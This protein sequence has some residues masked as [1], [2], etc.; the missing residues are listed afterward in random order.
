MIRDPFELLNGST[1]TKDK[2]IR[3]VDSKDQ[4]E[5]THFFL[6]SITT[7][8]SLNIP[9]HK[10]HEIAIIPIERTFHRSM[11]VIGAVYGEEKLYVPIWSGEGTS[12][13]T[14]KAKGI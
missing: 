5:A 1:I 6:A 12:F 13:R 9:Y 10:T 2:Y 14:F 3:L 4:K 7:F 8:S 11:A